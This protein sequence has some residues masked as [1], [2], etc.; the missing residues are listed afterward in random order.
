MKC[1]LPIVCLLSLTA[2]SP[3]QVLTLE[4]LTTTLTGELPS[5]ETLAVYLA[6]TKSL[7]QIAQELKESEQFEKHLTHF[8][9]EKLKITQPVDVLHIYQPYFFKKNDGSLSISD[10][11]NQKRVS[12]LILVGGNLNVFPKVLT[13]SEEEM[14]KYL[15]VLREPRN[16]S[17]FRRNKISTHLKFRESKQMYFMQIFEGDYDD[18]KAKLQS[19]EKYRPLL[20]TFNNAQ[21]CGG[22]T[23]TVTPFWSNTTVVA[24]RDAL[25]ETYCGANLQDCFPYAVNPANLDVDNTYRS[26]VFEAFTLEP[27]RIMAKTL[28]EE[29]KYS[30]ILTT[31]EG[32]INGYSLHYLR[33]FDSILRKKITRH[34]KNDDNEK[35]LDDRVIFQ[36]EA[37][38]LNSYP[39]LETDN[40]LQNIPLDDEKY[41]WVER[42]SD[43]HAG[44]LTTVAFHRAT[45][46]WRAKA[47]KARSA[48]LCREFV[49]APGAKADPTDTRPL[50]KRA[51]CSECHKFLEPLSKFFYRFPDTG[52]DSNYFYDH[53]K[54]AQTSTYYDFVCSDKCKENA[55]GVKGLAEILIDHE[56]E[57]FKKCAIKHAFEFILNKKMN[58]D[59]EE[60]L[61]PNYLSVY[62][63]SNENLWLVMEK[64]IASN[65]FK[66]SINVPTQ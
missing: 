15:N 4:R 29:R 5:K 56:D 24:C 63:S 18:V 30:T 8:Y 61:M 14:D 36:F 60:R 23:E 27:G 7:L 49:D 37:S 33:N 58:A 26:K 2:A 28:R 41:Y 65:E 54:S 35:T 13:A 55:D 9:Q 12:K 48:L 19:M 59:T 43:Q 47:N 46:G 38:E 53:L 45:N 52:N 31:S 16:Y 40:R 34:K 20:N 17:T 44:I 6:G 22:R 64:I 11:Q 51:Y 66:D 42:G 57:G 32:L 39:T 25:K 62:N 10:K 3:E 21:Y 50:E 1:I